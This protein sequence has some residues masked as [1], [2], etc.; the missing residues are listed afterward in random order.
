M[1]A[2]NMARSSSVARPTVSRTSVSVPI[3]RGR[4]AR[5]AVVMANS[6]AEAIRELDRLL[7]QRQREAE[8]AREAL[9]RGE[10]APQGSS[11]PTPSYSEPAPAPAQRGRSP[12]RPTGD[13]AARAEAVR[14]LDSLMAKRA[15]EAEEARAQMMAEQAETL[16]GAPQQSGF[17]PS[18]VRPTPA[19]APAPAPTQK[20]RSPV[21]PTGDAAARAEAVRM[22]DTLMAKRAVEAEEARAQMMAEQAEALAGA[23][24]QGGVA[25]TPAYS[26]PAPSPAPAQ[27]ARSPV[28]PTGNAASRAEA[29][30]ML[31]SLMAQRAAEA[32]EARSLLEAAE[33]AEAGA[34]QAGATKGV[35]QGTAQVSPALQSSRAEA[36]RL[37]DAV[38]AE[39]AAAAAAIPVFDVT[40]DLAMLDALQ[41]DFS[42]HAEELTGLQAEVTELSG[43][44][45]EAEGAVSREQGANAG[46][47]SQL[48]KTSYDLATT[49]ARA[50]SL[51]AQLSDAVA[52]MKSAE[53]S[54]AS[55]MRESKAV[56]KDNEARLTQYRDMMAQTKQAITDLGRQLADANSKMEQLARAQQAQ[57][58]QYAKQ[59]DTAKATIASLESA[60]VDARAAADRAADASAG[61]ASAI[62]S[63]LEALRVESSKTSK[64]AD[65]E[66]RAR[67]DAEAKLSAL[68]T[69]LG[70]LT[71]AAAFRKPS[72]VKPKPVVAPTRVAPSASAVANAMSSRAEAI[73]M[74]DALRN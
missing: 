58:K 28:R 43:A 31:D 70:Q 64:Q 15:V 1:A 47:R 20:V 6:R 16:A 13:A 50:S 49:K 59:I 19:S 17:A 67:V 57:E 60:V 56:Q 25:T 39:A 35:L 42:A 23:P 51:E 22:L 27:R 69:K 2:L 72:A 36:I 66:K 65:A 54:H 9:L 4:A 11:E 30:A 5:G 12:V 73:A 38:R 7:T 40:D 63:E 3:G 10:A 74:L 62:Q 53:Q 29:V 26:A 37:L 52:K 44:L 46:L 45:A 24:Q 68:R 55:Q 61:A 48:E 14:M 33:A 18:P 32:E 21:R 41:A 34:M 71:V 8:A